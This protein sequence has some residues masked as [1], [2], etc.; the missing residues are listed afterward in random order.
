VLLPIWQAE[1]ALSYAALG[2]LRMLYTGAMAGL[3]VPASL[4]AARFGA[5]L[6]LAVGT[7]MSAG[8]YLTIGLS[9]RGLCP[10]GSGAFG[11]WRRDRPRSIRWHQG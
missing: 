7:A 11:R 9:G 3:Q 4:L 2:A 5:P 1:F 10:V 6:V 8:A